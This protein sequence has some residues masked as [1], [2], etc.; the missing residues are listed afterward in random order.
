MSLQ[1]IPHPG[2]SGEG[3]DWVEVLGGQHLSLRGTAEFLEEVLHSVAR[4]ATDIEPRAVLA[5]LEDFQMELAEHLRC[6]EA[7][8]RLALALSGAPHW[9]R[10]AEHLRGDHDRFRASL[11]AL[12]GDAQQARETPAWSAIHH[13]FAAFRRA[14]RVHEEIE[15]HLL[16][17]I[18][19][20]DLGGGD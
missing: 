14:F 2:T 5:L 4:G 8:G 13:R 20:E 9:N 7:D 6:E 16:Q 10:R 15:H 11:G 19:L 17:R 1:P 18:Y 3:F 12:V